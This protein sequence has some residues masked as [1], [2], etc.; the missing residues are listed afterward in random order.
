MEKGENVPA[1]VR[2]DCEPFG[3][4][5]G[6]HA[7]RDN[8]IQ[9]VCGQGGPQDR[10]VA[11]EDAPRGAWP[12]Q[13]SLQYENR[14]ICGATLINSEWVLSA[15]H[16]FPKHA[17]LSRY[18]A[19]LGSHQ[20]S[21]PEP[22]SLRLPLSRAVGHTLYSGEGSS[23]DIALAQL[24][25]PVTFTS[26]V[27]PACLPDAGVHFPAGTL[28]WVTGWGSPQ[29]GA[30]LPAPMTLQQLQV[31]LIDPL[32]CDALYQRRS[33]M[34]EIQDDMVS[35]MRERRGA[36]QRGWVM[37]WGALQLLVLA[38]LIGT[39]ASMSDPHGKG[40]D[41]MDSQ[42]RACGCMP[43]A[44]P[45]RSLGVSSMHGEGT[46]GAGKAEGPEQVP[47]THM[48]RSNRVCGRP[49]AQ[50]R[51]VGGEDSMEG[52]WPWQASLLWYN[53]HLCGGSLISNQWVVT[54]A[55]CFQRS[56]NTSNYMVL[57]GV[58][59]LA[60][61]QPH[62][63][64]L[65]V[66]RIIRHPKYSGESSS[67]DIALVELERP[68]QF[69]DYILPIC[70]PAAS[71]QFPAGTKCWVTGWGNIQEGEDLPAP[72][73]LQKLQVPIIDQKTCRYLYNTALGEKFPPKA[74]QNDMMC[75]G[76][77]E[78]MKDTCKG[79]SGG[80]LVCKASKEWLL[81]GIISWGEG[82]AIKNRPGVY[83][84]L[85]SYEAWI[86]D[87]IP[88]IEFV[89]EEKGRNMFGNAGAGWAGRTSMTT[90]LPLLMGLLLMEV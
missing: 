36:A 43:V 31:P 76:Y 20:L 58:N 34:R 85:T 10:I 46:C 81:A 27:L 59:K 65:G 29:E 21:I 40:C 63:L 11:G 49:R 67:G 14:H 13:V 84:R 60:N 16:C 41:E 71:V 47:S 54:A 66:R 8:G 82:C 3:A 6:S 75:A 50:Y 89:P 64:S 7:A 62:K 5:P 68:I 26:Q 33:A 25:R 79:D 30:L 72:Q 61:S 24:G 51:N 86:H 42:S 28:C 55:H 53:K 1:F 15:A 57:L 87:H 80:P 39:A 35:G 17:E 78:G 73:T 32:P 45:P 70:L 88:D 4:R 44:S 56:M 69:T 77:A 2:L 83:I 74:I 38:G 22:G 23:G 19:V 12:W 9:T 37:G 52:E 18:R 48:T 90:W